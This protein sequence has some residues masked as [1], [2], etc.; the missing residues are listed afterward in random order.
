[1]SILS[2][3]FK[4]KWQHKQPDTRKAALA[5]LNPNAEADQAIILKLAEQDSD[6]SVREAALARIS[7]SQ[8]LARLHQGASGQF[9]ADLEQRLYALAESQSLSLFDLI[10]DQD[11]LSDMIIHA[12]NPESFINGLARVE[13]PAALLNIALHAKTSKLRQA[14]AELI[15]T[16]DDLKQLTQ[17]LKNRDKGVYQIAKQKLEALKAQAKSEAMHTQQLSEL[18]KLIEEHARTDNTKLYQ[19]KLESL[20]Q[21]W[22]SLA[23]LAT[24]ADQ[25]RFETAQAACQTR[26]AE[27]SQA[28]AAA[29]Q[30]AQLAKA[31][32]D[33]LSATLDTLE[34]T[35][36]RLRE[37]A[38]TSQ[39]ASSLDAIIKTQETRWLEA[40]KQ[41]DVK[42]SDQKHYQLL[43]GQLRHYLQALS[44]LGE[45]G[46]NL[47]ALCKDIDEAQSKPDQA[48]ALTIGKSSKA[49]Q[50]ALAQVDWP[51][52]FA[53]P[54][55][56]TK[57]EQALGLSRDLNEK[58]AHS[59]DD[60]LAEI[61][62]EQG[63]LD[64]ALDDKQV[65]ASSAHLKRIQSLASQL[66][67]KQAE[68]VHQQLTL[69]IKQLNDLRDWQ[70]YASSPRQLAL[71]EAMERLAEKHIDPQDKADKI[72]AMQQEWKSLG[73]AADESLWQR[74]KTASDLAYEPCKAFFGEQAA[75]K[76]SNLE[77]R[78]T[79]VNEL[80]HFVNNNDWGNANW[81]AAEQINRRAR[82]EWRD[83]YPVD[84]RK[85]RGLQKQFN[86]VLEQLDQHLNT[87]RSNNLVLKTQVVEQ[88]EALIAHD[89]LNH[90][91]NEAKNL[92]K[93]WQEIGITEHKKD[94]ALWQR[95][96]KACD[97]IFARR[98][99]ER[100]DRN[101]AFAQAQAQADA[102]ISDYQ[103]K[104][105]A[106]QAADSEALS[107]LLTSL[108]QDNKALPT[109]GKK[110]ASAHQDAVEALLTQIKA[111][112][113]RQDSVRVLAQWQQCTTIA[114]II[115][116]SQRQ[117]SFDEAQ[118]EQAQLAA[119]A[120]SADLSKALKELW[121]SAKAGALKAS[122]MLDE[123]AARELCI[124]CEIAAGM[125]SPEQDKDLRM[126]LQV[127]RLSEGMS[128]NESASR[129]QQLETLLIQW[130]TSL[131]L[132]AEAEQ[133]FETRVQASIQHLFA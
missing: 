129:E 30:A 32:G 83:A 56:I 45:H 22:Q 34:Q 82:Q 15:E 115:R 109:L 70:G 84:H 97:A 67:H 16:E 51:S 59:A 118:F 49:L 9:K 88:A 35:L 14:A 39:E 4:P 107:N 125:D 127:S 3:F 105:A 71:C 76:L 113:K 40:T 2:K 91:M 18:I 116:Q 8:L 33:E 96:R 25:Q 99:Q 104:I 110:A 47:A 36:A 57:A 66:N 114:N 106:A 21:R 20:N 44:K 53:Q 19:S 103:G 12:S 122:S 50:K 61:K 5:E 124:R 63:Q 93:Q 94:R 119:N 90:A 102:L 31:G 108:R 86:Q 78:R 64:A 11:I 7:D 58:L 43:M 23:A 87:E 29:E 75:L 6:T 112:I 17:A 68:Q 133:R 54:Q 79:L 120:I 77:K 60:I 48:Q 28:Q 65:K 37:T 55:S 92:Q 1:M 42:K 72:K 62:R 100:D 95:F 123:N 89:D 24:S 69:R 85:N 126:Q 10:V 111:L 73:G 26:I 52:D 117:Q 27:H 13:N 41:V 131:G 98:D 128:S 74:F 80:E 81:K 46:D 130:F 101:Q 38:A 132:E 121:I